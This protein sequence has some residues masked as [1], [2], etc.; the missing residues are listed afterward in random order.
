[1]DKNSEKEIV[2]LVD[3]QGEI[4][5]EVGIDRQEMNDACFLGLMDELRNRMWDVDETIDALFEL[6]HEMACWKLIIKKKH[7]L[8]LETQRLEAVRLSKD[9][10]D[11]LKEGKNHGEG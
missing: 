1:M 11:L 7:L 8:E 10:Q 3:S 4:K 6:F 2:K 5:G 9:F